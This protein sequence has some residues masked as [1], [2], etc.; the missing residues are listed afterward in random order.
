MKTEHFTVTSHY[1]IYD[2]E[3]EDSIGY[4]SITVDSSDAEHI[5][6]VPGDYTKEDMAKSFIEGVKFVL[7]EGNITVTEARAA[8]DTVDRG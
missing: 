3:F 1:S 4:I 2:P 6:D 5:I 7:G 8:D